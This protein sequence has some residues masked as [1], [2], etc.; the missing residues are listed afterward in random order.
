MGHIAN[1]Q[2]GIKRNAAVSK[3]PQTPI[4]PATKQSPWTPVSSKK[5]KYSFKTGY[6]GKG[7]LP[8][9]PQKNH[10]LLKGR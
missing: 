3:I 1:I 6:K 4:T 7:L 9:T 8:K 2:K 10:F 5:L